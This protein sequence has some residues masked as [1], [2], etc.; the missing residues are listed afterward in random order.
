MCLCQLAFAVTVSPLLPFLPSLLARFTLFKNPVRS[1]DGDLDDKDAP[2][3]FGGRF[4]GAFLSSVPAVVPR[5]LRDRRPAR[6]VKCSAWKRIAELAFLPA[7]A[8]GDA[9]CALYV[10]FSFV[11]RVRECIL[12]GARSE[13]GG[14]PMEKDTDESVSEALFIY[15]FSYL[16]PGAEE[17]QRRKRLHGSVDNHMGKVQ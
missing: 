5:C 10:V 6:E 9:P 3:A 16:P 13:A 1:G 7:G 17:L 11:V 8:V 15:L 2:A 4:A 12:L 14:F